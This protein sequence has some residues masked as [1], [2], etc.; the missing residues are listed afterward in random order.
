MA[1]TALIVDD[2]PSFR[3][4]ARRMLEADGYEVIGEAASGSAARVPPCPPVYPRGSAV[5]RLA[6]VDRVPGFGT[7]VWSVESA[8]PPIG[9]GLADDPTT[10][11]AYAAA[12]LAVASLRYDPGRPL[13]LVI[14]KGYSVA[15]QEQRRRNGG[16]SRLVWPGLL[17]RLDRRDTSYRH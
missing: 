5:A 16:Q 14:D 3:A 12:E 6:A 11:V 2:H 17:R 4:S 13:A 7:P 1:R 9:A 15:M 8:R 10:A